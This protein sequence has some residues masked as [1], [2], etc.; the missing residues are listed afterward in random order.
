[1][2][3]QPRHEQ[4]G[5]SHHASW[6]NLPTKYK[7]DEIEETS[8]DV[9]MDSSSAHQGFRKPRGI[10]FQLFIGLEV[11]ILNVVEMME[12][13]MIVVSNDDN[14]VQKAQ[15]EAHTDRVKLPGSNSCHA[16]DLSVVKPVNREVGSH[17]HC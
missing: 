5:C 8:S 2:I 9:V 6:G 17:W 11:R 14:P 12:T 1:M 13:K 7:D 15:E 3:R 10:F 4:D 16:A